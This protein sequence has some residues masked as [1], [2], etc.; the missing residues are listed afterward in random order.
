MGKKKLL[1]VSVILVLLLSIGFTACVDKDKTD[2]TT[3]KIE[4][5]KN[6]ETIENNTSDEPIKDES[7]SKGLSFQPLSG[8]ICYINGIGNCADEDIYIPKYIDGYEVIGIADKAFYNCKNIKSI[9]IPSTVKSIG[10]YA[11]YK[12][13]NLV[14]VTLPNSIESI[15]AQ[16]FAY[17]G[18]LANVTIPNRVT[19]L[20]YNT[21][22]G[23]HKLTSLTIPNSIVFIDRGVLSTNYI[24]NIYFKGTC[25]QWESITNYDDYYSFRKYTIYCTDGK[26]SP[27]STN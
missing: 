12:C 27:D 3:R 17:C 25:S 26:I 10:N 1:F 23:C 9:T 11:F 19:R 24:E 8:G 5:T 22:W 7:G 6:T 14:S 21:F 4:T 18:S 20:E 2:N 13:T 16:A 15:G